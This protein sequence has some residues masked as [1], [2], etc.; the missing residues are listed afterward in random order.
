MKNIALKTVLLN[1]FLAVNVFAASP[2]QTD[3]LTPNISFPADFMTNVRTYGAMGDGVN[4]DT[5]AIQAALNDGR[6]I[7]QDYF[8]RPKALYFP[9]GTYVVSNTLTWRGCCVLLQG[10]GSGATVIKLKNNAVGYNDPN[11][12]KAVIKT[13]NGNMSFRQNIWDLAINTGTGNA[14]AIG[15]DWIASNYGALRNVL[16]TSGDGS[17]VRGLDMTRAWAGPCL[18]KNV[19]IVGFDYGIALGHAEYGP[20]FENVTLENQRVTGFLNDGNTPAIRNFVSTN[21]VP[22]IQN[23]RNYGHV[24]LLNGTFNGGAGNVSAIENGGLLYA[25]NVRASGYQSA[26]RNGATILSGNTIGEYVSGTVHSLFKRP[27]PTRSLNLP[28]KET[29]EFHDGNAANWAKFTPTYYGDT[30]SLQ[31]TLNSGKQTVYFPFGGY[32]SYNERAVTVPDTVKRIVGFSAIVNGDANGTNGGGIKFVVESNNTE[33]LI[34]E[35]FGYGVKIEHR[36]KRPVVL[37]HGGYEYTSI[38]GAGNVFLEDVGA[39]PFEMHA[40]QDVWARQF[41]NEFGGTKIKNRGGRLWILGLKTERAGTVIETTN[42][43]MTELLGTRIYPAATFTPAELQQAAFI[44]RDS[45][46]SLIFSTSVYCQN[47]GY[48]IFVEET[49]HGETRKL[50]ANQVGGRMPLYIGHQTRSAPGV[51]RPVAPR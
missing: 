30:G 46:I 1:I 27:L 29:P 48:N 5:A 23:P 47:C 25:R 19:K 14:G 24:I 51:F 9:P 22:A 33:P 13:I 45:R 38:A 43:G 32:F 37:K 2:A 18:V 16:I 26:V 8:G 35:Q 21:T 39:G 41:N 12:P 6:T 7:D 44:N 40:S 31:A 36:G 42:G 10:A 3:F 50:F 17:G 49:R 28:I 34:I 4:D 11:N 20:T 15:L